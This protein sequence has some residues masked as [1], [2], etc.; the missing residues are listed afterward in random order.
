MRSRFQIGSAVLITSILNVVACADPSEPVTASRSTTSAVTTR[1]ESQAMLMINRLDDTNLKELIGLDVDQ[2]AVIL[3][4]RENDPTRVDDDREYPI[5][6][7]IEGK[8]QVFEY[9][10]CYF[11]TGRPWSFWKPEVAPEHAVD[12]YNDCEWDGG[13]KEGLAEGTWNAFL[14]Y[15]QTNAHRPFQ[16]V[17]GFVDSKYGVL[18]PLKLQV[19]AFPVNGK[20]WDDATAPR[21]FFYTPH[22]HK[23]SDGRWVYRMLVGA[24]PSTFGDINGKDYYILGVEGGRPLDSIL[25]LDGNMGTFN[26]GVNSLESSE[27]QIVTA[28]LRTGNVR[29]MAGVEGECNT[30]LEAPG[31]K[32]EPGNVAASWCFG[33]H[34]YVADCGATTGLACRRTTEW[35]QTFVSCAR[36]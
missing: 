31:G 32:C 5:A 15:A 27:A 36:F 9:K 11:K 16:E 22:I 2:R 13:R 33:T 17:H 7:P 34:R 1:Y 20:M 18:D 14:Q 25:S 4:A 35:D 21:G 6:D 10:A 28:S 3:A 8:R 19:L 29:Q 12:Y 30:L 23:Q 26:V 24:N